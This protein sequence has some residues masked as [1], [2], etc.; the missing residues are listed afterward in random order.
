[1]GDEVSADVKIPQTTEVE[2][3]ELLSEVPFVKQSSEEVPN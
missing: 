2:G 3:S 1:M